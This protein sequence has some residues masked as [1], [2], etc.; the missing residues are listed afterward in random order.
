MSLSRC[1]IGGDE[2]LSRRSTKP[3][4]IFNYTTKLT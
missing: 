1:E 4:A 2:K 3:N